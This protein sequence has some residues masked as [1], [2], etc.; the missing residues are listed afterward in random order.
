MNLTLN[1][2]N[3]SLLNVTQDP[4]TNFSC[5]KFSAQQD[6]L[7]KN[8]KYWVGGVS[9]CA[10][11]I[12][13]IILNLTAICA[14]LL[15]RLS[16]RNNFNQLIAILFLLDTIYLVFSLL[17]TLQIRLGVDHRNLILIFPKFTYPVWNISL[18]LSIFL[19]VGVAHERYIAIKYP[20]IHRQRMRS[21][22][23]RRTNLLKYV[24]SAMTFAI[25]FNITKFLEI[26]IAWKESP[27]NESTS[28]NTDAKCHNC[29]S[30]L[31]WNITNNKNITFP[32][33]NSNDMITRY[34]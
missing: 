29:T 12:T 14:I 16:S 3:E 32:S 34:E 9:V 25:I 22:K 11:S 1:T 6:F 19:T 13:G 4:M 20:I 15:T 18:T 33:M 7:L 28:N 24:V 5:P 21:A 27:L 2:V 8:A 17:T 26:E 23:Y 30:S 31:V 10:V